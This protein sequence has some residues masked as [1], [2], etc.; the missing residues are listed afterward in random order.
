VKAGFEL[1]SS[2][3]STNQEASTSTRCGKECNLLP[4]E[5]LKVYNEASTVHFGLS[6]NVLHPFSSSLSFDRFRGMTLA[7]T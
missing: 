1:T 2:F 5:E 7:L 4:F 6:G 3:H